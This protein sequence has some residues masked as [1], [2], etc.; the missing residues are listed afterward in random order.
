MQ[1]TVKRDGRQNERKI[2]TTRKRNDRYLAELFKGQK[3][4]NQC[5]NTP[6]VRRGIKINSLEV[7]IGIK[8][9]D[10]QNNNI[11]LKNTLYMEEH[12]ICTHVQKGRPRGS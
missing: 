11:T 10:N 12:H 4:M 1:T 7:E 8:T 9:D 6:N 3:N 5:S 2:I